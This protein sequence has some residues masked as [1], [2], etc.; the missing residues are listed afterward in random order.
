MK[1]CPEQVGGGYIFLPST[2][3]HLFMGL[4]GRLLPEVPICSEGQGHKRHL[5]RGQTGNGK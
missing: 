3:D 4:Q 2:F 1:G 5:S